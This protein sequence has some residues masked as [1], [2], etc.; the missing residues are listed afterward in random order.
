[1]AVLLSVVGSFG[2]EFAH[3]PLDHSGV[4]AVPSFDVDFSSHLVKEVLVVIVIS[5]EGGKN[6]V[7]I[8]WTG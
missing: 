1:M 8:S 2:G 4:A 7:S 3:F 5:G 6:P